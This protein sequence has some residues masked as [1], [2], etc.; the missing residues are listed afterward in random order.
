MDGNQVTLRTVIE[1]H[2]VGTGHTLASFAKQSG[3]N[4][5]SL[6]AILHG[7]PPKPI[8]LAQL[9]AITA[10]LGL[11]DG[12]L[13][14]LYPDEC[15][16]ERRISRRRIE[17]FLIRCAEIGQSA[18]VESCIERMMEYPRALDILFAVGEKLFFQEKTREA[19]IFYARIALNDADFHS[20]RLA[21]SQYRL[22]RMRRSANDMEEKLCAVIAFEPFRRRLP[23]ELQLDGLLELIETCSALQRWGDAERYAGE[24]E[25]LALG[26]ARE[27]SMR[28]KA[29]S[30]AGR[31]K[32]EH[33]LIHYAIQAH[34]RK[35]TAL[36]RQGKY[37]E[38]RGFAAGYPEIGS[39]GELNERERLLVEEC[40]AYSKGYQ[41]A[42]ELLL[43]DTSLLSEVLEYMER[44]PRRVIPGLVFVLTAANGNGFS[45][46]HVLQRFAGRIAEYVQTRDTALHG[47]AFRLL[48]EL[49]T[50]LMNQEKYADG[51]DCLLRGL[52]LARSMNSAKDMVY[53]LARFET[54]RE[55]ADG[56]QL[57]EY[58]RLLYADGVQTPLFSHQPYTKRQ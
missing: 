15:F 22:F 32:S 52:G 39:F 8:S 43:G 49:A 13:Y 58:R 6:S 9:D 34:M 10:A 30:D 14:P 46:D 40:L 33:P 37:A 26:I 7:N 41:Y 45:V 50:Y 28:R 38:A 53:G 27:L 48:D 54:F 18:C 23:E 47:L 2:L 1:R 51:L 57:A 16:S 36:V 44:H 5:G 55:Y 25:A 35:G 21:V 12:E 19:G 42:L 24:L 56:R 3:Q 20:E 17:P 31:P 29:D 11:G 4:R